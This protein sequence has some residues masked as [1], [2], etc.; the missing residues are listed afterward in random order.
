MSAAT[1]PRDTPGTDTTISRR[2]EQAGRCSQPS[3]SSSQAPGTSS[4]AILAVSK[5]HVYTTDAHYVFS[6]L[7]TWGWIVLILGVIQLCAGVGLLSG[8]IWAVWFAIA[9]A[10]V[11][12]IGQLMFLPAYPLWA[13][14]M[15]TLDILIIYGLVI[16]HGSIR[17]LRNYDKPFGRHAR[18]VAHDPR[19]AEDDQHHGDQADRARQEHADVAVER[20]TRQL[21]QPPRHEGRR[22]RAHRGSRAAAG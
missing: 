18:S 4:R 11:N 9:V 8:S 20:S 3:C 10:G 17:A 16:Y 22:P 6:D 19:H 1:A 2:G 15:F 21:Q 14:A 13:L 7:R 5:S 12:A